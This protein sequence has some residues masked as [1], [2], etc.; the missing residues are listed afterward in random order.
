[1]QALDNWRA[2]RLNHRNHSHAAQQLITPYDHDQLYMVNVVIILRI[3]AAGH[4]N[5]STAQDYSAARLGVQNAVMH[6]KLNPYPA[7]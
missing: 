4:F 7:P 2:G 1:V 6:L 5:N 3:F